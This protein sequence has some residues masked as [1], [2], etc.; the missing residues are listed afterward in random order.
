[1]GEELTNMELD[2]V[3][4]LLPHLPLTRWTNN[5][6]SMSNDPIR[7]TCLL[8]DCRRSSGTVIFLSSLNV[9]CFQQ[10]PDLSN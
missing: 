2:P 7:I 4:F 10:V 6:T 3:I 8:S 1:M 9:D 5:S